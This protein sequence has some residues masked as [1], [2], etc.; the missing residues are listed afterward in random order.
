MQVR[1]FRAPPFFTFHHV[2]AFESSDGHEL[3]VDMSVYDDPEIMLELGMDK[4]MG[5]GTVSQCVLVM[6]LG[7]T[8]ACMSARAR[9]P[10]LNLEL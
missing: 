4:I 6:C 5:Q 9:L 3:Y 1:T 10:S 8:W 2:N 7:C